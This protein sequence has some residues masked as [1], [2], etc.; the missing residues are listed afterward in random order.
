MKKLKQQFLDYKHVH[1]HFIF[2]FTWDITQVKFIDLKKTLQEADKRWGS[3]HIHERPIIWAKKKFH[4]YYQPNLISENIKVLQINDTLANKAIICVPAEEFKDQKLNRH[5]KIEANIQYTLRIFENGTGTFTFIVCLD[6]KF[7]SFKNI[8]RTMRLAPNIADNKSMNY[9]QS[10][11]LNNFIENKKNIFF[12]NELSSFKYIT[13]QQIFWCL[14]TKQY[15]ECLT[16][17]Q[18][19]WGKLWL[20]DDLLGLKNVTPAPVNWQSPFVFIIAEI[21]Q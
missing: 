9:A 13:L 6:K 11:L 3:Y 1:V 17:E 15:P 7:A 16:M 18:Y 21:E 20:D 10:F 14:F 8:H 5:D 2:S 4:S 12:Q 19:D